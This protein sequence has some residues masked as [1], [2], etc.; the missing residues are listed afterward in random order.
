[1]MDDG[2]HFPVKVSKNTQSCMS[3]KRLIREVVCIDVSQPEMATA[4]IQCVTFTSLCVV[5]L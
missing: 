5:I 1:M 2:D 3:E 4:P